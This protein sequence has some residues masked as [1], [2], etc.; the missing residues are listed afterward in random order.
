VA[1]FSCFDT[2]IKFK[3]EML[4]INR[5]SRTGT[6]FTMVEV[7]VVAPKRQISTSLSTERLLG[8][9]GTSSKGFFQNP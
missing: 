1:A 9:S 4:P 3:L 6:L 2:F 8:T 7:T 5:R